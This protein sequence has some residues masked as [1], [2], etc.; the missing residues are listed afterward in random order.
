MPHLLQGHLRFVDE[1]FL[2]TDYQAEKAT[3]STKISY[4][5]AAGM[6]K[7][8]GEQLALMK[9]PEILERFD[10]TENVKRLLADSLSLIAGLAHK[11]GY[12]LAE[13]MR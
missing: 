4:A 9:E 13:L 3:A 8:N 1:D 5:N 10:T 11:E 2:I 6:L 12:T 7:A